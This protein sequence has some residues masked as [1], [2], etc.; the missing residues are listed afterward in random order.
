MP[1]IKGPHDGSAALLTDA[2]GRLRL[3]RDCFLQ[4]LVP[5]VLLRILNVRPLGA[6]VEKTRFE[7]GI[8]SSLRRFAV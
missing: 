7:L 6:V 8:V 5:L 2:G 1:R 4:K 3:A